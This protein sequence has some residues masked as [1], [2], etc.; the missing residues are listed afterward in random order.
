MVLKNNNTTILIINNTWYVAK[1]IKHSHTISFK[2][3][4][5]NMTY[6]YLWQWTTLHASGFRI[7]S[8]GTICMGNYLGR[9]RRGFNRVGLLRLKCMVLLQDT[10]AGL[11]VAHVHGQHGHPTC[12]K[13]SSAPS[14]TINFV[15]RVAF[16]QFPSCKRSSKVLRTASGS[17]G[18]TSRRENAGAHGRHVQVL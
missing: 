13:A 4:H 3:I 17:R 5:I 10:T 12:T 9:G 11:S 8:S 2:C 7:F 15:D 1:V 16:R 18:E 6:G 14:A